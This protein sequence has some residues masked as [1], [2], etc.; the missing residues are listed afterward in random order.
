MY[1]YSPSREASRP[2][3]GPSSR[4]AVPSA[5]PNSQESTGRSRHTD[6]DGN[7]L[8]RAIHRN[9]KDYPPRRV[10]GRVARAR[11]FPS[12]KAARTSGPATQ[13]PIHRMSQYATF[14]DPHAE[15]ERPVALPSAAAIQLASNVTLQP[16]LSR[17]GSGPGLILVV[18]ASPT[19]AEGWKAPLDPSPLLKW[20]E[21]GYCV[22][23]VIV[24]D[25]EGAW[26]LPKVLEAG[27]AA[28]EGLKEFV[29]QRIG[30]VGKLVTCARRDWLLTPSACAVYE[31][32]SLV[33]L[34]SL[35]PKYPSI[36]AV[37]AYAVPET[38]FAIP[39]LLH[40][41][42]SSQ[43]APAGA[44][45]FT[46]TTDSPYFSLPTFPIEYHGTHASVSHS[47]S[48]AFL[49]APGAVEGPSFDLGAIWEVR[50][51]RPGF[52]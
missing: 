17:H 38:A 1:H 18:P 44:Q 30:V 52:D 47:R 11:P 33:E 22:L 32:Q 10:L 13:Q 42:T 16:P 31:P 51:L 7:Q 2:E 8:P 24:S 29:K 14:Y 40:L 45:S 50:T 35:V 6:D 21:E 48:L 49:K 43:P 15:S 19:P 27:L 5:Q 39:T 20:A 28:M 41:P 37:I 34:A 26:G 9:D 4:D 3:S 12:Q 25:A 46:Y 23:Q 36:K